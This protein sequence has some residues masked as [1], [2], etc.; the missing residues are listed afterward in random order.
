[1]KKLKYVDT[2]PIYLPALQFHPSGV[3]LP[4][5]SNEIQV[6]D[7]EAT[8]LLKIRNGSKQCFIESGSVKKEE[9]KKEEPKKMDLED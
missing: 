6:T 5:G 7:G 9:V 4:S 1:M 8:H 3:G 2:R